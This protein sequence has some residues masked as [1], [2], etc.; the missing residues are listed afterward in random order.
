MP[1]EFEKNRG[2]IVFDEDG[3][4]DAVFNDW[5]NPIVKSEERLSMIKYYVNGRVY[6]YAKS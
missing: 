4:C 5:N 2:Y 1:L 6:I 3:Q